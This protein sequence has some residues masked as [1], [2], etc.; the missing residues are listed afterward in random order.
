ML[1]SRRDPEPYGLVVALIEPPH[2]EF[3]PRR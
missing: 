1:R 2:P 3:Q